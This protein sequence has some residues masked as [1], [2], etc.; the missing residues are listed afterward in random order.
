MSFFFLMAVYLTETIGDESMD[1]LDYRPFGYAEIFADIHE[2]TTE[3]KDFSTEEESISDNSNTILGEY[4]NCL[5]I[6]GNHW[7]TASEVFNQTEVLDEDYELVLR[8]MTKVSTYISQC[9]QI[10]LQLADMPTEFSAPL[11]KMTAELNTALKEDRN[12]VMET[13]QNARNG[14]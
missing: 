1:A 7:D 6:A 13:W 9:G 3:L 12:Y 14:N 2:Y 10:G 5:E 8:L 11:N 4:I